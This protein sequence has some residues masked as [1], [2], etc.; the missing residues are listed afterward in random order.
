LASAG[1]TV[2]AGAP[3]SFWLDKRNWNT[4]VDGSEIEIIQVQAIQVL[5]R[6]GTAAPK[7]PHIPRFESV[8]FGCARNWESLDDEE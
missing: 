8:A 3:S 4:Q 1:T 7:A 2:P 6:V 5:H